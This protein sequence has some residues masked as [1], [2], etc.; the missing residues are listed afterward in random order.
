MYF[1]QFPTI[2]YSLDGGKTQF[3]MTDFFIRIKADYNNV[4]TSLA[5][6]EYD[7]TEGETPEMLAARIY[8]DSQLHWVIL[9]T[10]EIIDPRYDWPISTQALNNYIADKYGVGN[11]GQIHHYVND[12]GDVVHSSY[13]G[14][15]Y[16][17]SNFDYENE[18][19]ETKR[20]I[21]I[22]KAKFVPEFVKSFKAKI[23]FNG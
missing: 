20:P 10:N 3:S 12:D 17:V 13:A 21:K 14:A 8:G 4:Y 16:P 9:I 2:N 1:N 22:L 6:E 11:Q 7:I 19:N 5:Y 23:Q 18:V 15:K